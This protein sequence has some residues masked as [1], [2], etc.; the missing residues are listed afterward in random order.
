MGL[1]IPKLSGT[2][3]I[4]RTTLVSGYKII[5]ETFLWKGLDTN[6]VPFQTRVKDRCA[7][8]DVDHSVFPCV[9]SVSESYVY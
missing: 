4:C 2:E 6:E 1:K 5:P 7:L 9:L 8:C 3:R